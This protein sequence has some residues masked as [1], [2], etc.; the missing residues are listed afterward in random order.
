MDK[1]QHNLLLAALNSVLAKSLSKEAQI[2]ANEKNKVVTLKFSSTPRKED[3]EAALLFYSNAYGP[4]YTIDEM[5]HTETKDELIT[6]QSTLTPS[7]GWEDDSD[8]MDEYYG[9]ESSDTSN[10]ENSYY[11]YKNFDIK[12]GA[13]KNHTLPQIIKSLEK[14]TEGERNY[15]YLLKYYKN[16][17][18]TLAPIIQI[19]GKVADGFGR[20]LLA[21]ALGLSKIKVVNYHI[22]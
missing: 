5:Q 15:S 13:L 6:E 10:K 21:W 7:S 19:D 3:L 16:G 2:K 1:P 9:G 20:I 17:T 8:D 4:E 12:K 11:F 22:A 14:H 18:L